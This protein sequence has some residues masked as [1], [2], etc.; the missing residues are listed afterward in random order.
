MTHRNSDRSGDSPVVTTIERY[1]GAPDLC[2]IH[3]DPPGE[4]STDESVMTAWISAEEGS[5]CAVSSKR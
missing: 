5:Y 4:D 2:T 3:L 1:V